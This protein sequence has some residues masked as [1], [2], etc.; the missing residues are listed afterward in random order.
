MNNQMAS[1]IFKLRQNIVLE[2]DLVLAKMELDAFLPDDVVQGIADIAAVAQRV[3]QLTELL[4][5]GALDSYVRQDGTQAYAAN[6]PLT[7][8]PDL[9]RCVSFIQRIYC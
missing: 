2:G 5:F 4:K 6:G 9:I 3:P 1:F 7:L 8:L